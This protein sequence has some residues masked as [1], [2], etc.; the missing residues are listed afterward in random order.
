M[1]QNLKEE[2]LI[3]LLN[4]SEELFVND[5]STENGRTLN[6]ELVTVFG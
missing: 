6:R 3:Q 1:A 4:K 2:S 5:F